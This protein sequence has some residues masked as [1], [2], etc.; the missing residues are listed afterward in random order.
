MTKNHKEFLV[1]KIRTQYIEKGHSKLEQ[2]KKLDG[3]VKRPA[4]IFAYVF[5]SVGAIIMGSGMSLI[6]TDIGDTV[7]IGNTMAVGIVVGIIGMAM[8][9]VNFPIYKKFLT[10]RRRKYAG[11][12]ISMSQEV[13]GD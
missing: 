8:A 7:G 3:K 4:N 5:G 12:I 10:S 9:I 11:E 13:I 6:M 2:L 1:E